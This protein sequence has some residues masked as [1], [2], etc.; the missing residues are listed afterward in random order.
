M[1]Q[2]ELHQHHQH[3][4][5]HATRVEVQRLDPQRQEKAGADGVGQCRQR[6]APERSSCPAGGGGSGVHR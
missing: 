4:V 1:Q 2:D 5:G 3:A 6:P